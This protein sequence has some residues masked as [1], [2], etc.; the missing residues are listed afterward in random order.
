MKNV[1][2]AAAYRLAQFESAPPVKIVQMLNAGAIRF[3]KAALTFKPSQPEYRESIRRAEDI[4]AELRA[5]LDHEPNPELSANLEN[6]YVFMQ[7][8]LGQAII[9]RDPAGIESSIS[10][11]STLLEGW[12]GVGETWENESGPAST[13]IDLRNVG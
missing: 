10:I 13:S 8:Q 6:L 7:S 1:Q 12:K 11:L 5:S 3:L 4:I 9:D 2:A